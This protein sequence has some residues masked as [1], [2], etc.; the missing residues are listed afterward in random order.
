MGIIQWL[1]TVSSLN[2]FVK[3]GSGNS[4]L[5]ICPITFTR[6]TPFIQ[7]DPNAI[8]FGGG[9]GVTQNKLPSETL[10]RNCM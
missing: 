7:C 4:V 10:L 3:S 6:R 9:Y 8:D 2:C 1:V 5:T